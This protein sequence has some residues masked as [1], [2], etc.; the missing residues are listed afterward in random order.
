MITKLVWLLASAVLI[1]LGTIG[2]SFGM[3][4]RQRSIARSFLRDFSNL[5][6]GSSTFDDAQRVANKYGGIPWYTSDGNLKCDFR[7]CELK[8]IFENNSLTRLRLARYVALIGK[9]SVR[10]GLVSGREIS[11]VKDT[12]SFNPLEFDVVEGE[13]WTR[14]LRPPLQTDCGLRRLNVD[15]SGNAHTVKIILCDSSTAEQLSR[16]HAL[17]VSCLAKLF[18][19]NDPNAMFPPGVPYRGVPSQTH[20]DDW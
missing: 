17:D 5:R 4:L 19:C 6:V 2:L 15:T 14:Q 1:S 16:A 20:S 3:A 7:E 8:F 12:G 10:N 18:G 13:T 9:V 11:F